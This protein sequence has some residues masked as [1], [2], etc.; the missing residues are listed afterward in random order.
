MAKKSII[1][2]VTKL[3]NLSSNKIKKTT[4]I[5]KKKKQEKKS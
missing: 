3:L 2:K 5:V 1:L 4:Q